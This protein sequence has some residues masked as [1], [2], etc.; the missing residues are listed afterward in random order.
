MAGMYV[1][2][3]GTGSCVKQALL[4]KT[5]FRT[6]LPSS[7]FDVV[8]LLPPAELMG[9]K[10]CSRLNLLYPDLYDKVEHAREQVQK[11]FMWQLET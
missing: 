4:A 7:Y 11:T 8:S 9:R 10:L 3:G 6:V 1:M 2:V 5:P